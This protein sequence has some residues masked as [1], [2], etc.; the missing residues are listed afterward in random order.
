[1]TQALAAEWAPQ[2]R[3][4]ALAPRHVA[5]PL[6]TELIARGDVDGGALEGRAPAG[7]LGRPEEVARAALFLASDDAAYVAGVVLPVDGGWLVGGHGV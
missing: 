4:N 5:T 3:V 7:R 2:I 1:M 6:L